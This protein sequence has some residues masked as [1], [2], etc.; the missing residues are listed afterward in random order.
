M[1]KTWHIEN[2]VVIAVL[3]VVWAAT[4]CKPIE[5][6]GSAAVFCGFCCA[7]IGARLTEREAQREKPSVECHRLFWWF[8]VIKEIAWAVY[9]AVQGSWS[10]LVGC[11]V[12]AAY[13]AWRALWRR[14][15]PLSTEAL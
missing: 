3:A 12:F 8:F 11:A 5:A 1:I 7:S 9:F 4:G 14:W 13:P 6:L 15:H 10:A 2:A